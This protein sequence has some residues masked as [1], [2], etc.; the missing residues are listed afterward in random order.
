MCSVCVRLCASSVCMSVCVCATC[1][2]EEEDKGTFLGSSMLELGDAAVDWWR[3]ASVT[4][5]FN[6]SAAS[7]SLS[8]FVCISI[9][10]PLF[11]L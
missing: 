8:L 10:V 6:R 1:V 9:S 4:A 7:S 2:A 5:A 3:G 11:A